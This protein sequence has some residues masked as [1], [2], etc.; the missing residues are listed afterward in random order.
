MATTAKGEKREFEV[1]LALWIDLLGYGSMLESAAWDPTSQGAKRALGRI[2][3]FQDLVSKASMRHFPTF[4]MNDGAIA[5]RDMSPRTGGVTFDFL[6]RAIDLHTDINRSE[7]SNG[8]P[9]ARSVLAAGFRVRRN[10]DYVDRLTSGEGQVI[11]NKLSTN[12]ISGDQAINHALMARH[13][14]DSTPEL[15]H[16][17]AMTKAY[18]ADAAGT[19]AGFAGP[20]LYID[21][22]IFDGEPP[23]W[24]NF[25]NQVS[26]SGRGMSGLFGCFSSLDEQKAHQGKLVGV[27]HA[28]EIAAALSTNPDIV[29]T[30]RA[31]RIGNLRK[32]LPKKI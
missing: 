28:F 9:G 21:M 14:S 25:S 11:K 2:V 12:F 8:H 27:R 19:R 4:V 7:S 22:N 26:W 17:Y 18:L 20:N 31:S 10:F 13:H 3:C 5:F 16:N 32:A 24:V 15:Q 29:K 30:I 1:S 23:A 6:R